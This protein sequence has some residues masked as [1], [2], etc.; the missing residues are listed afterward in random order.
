MR[1]V[2]SFR[3]RETADRLASALQARGLHTGVDQTDAECVVSILEEDRLS[4]AQQI[5]SEFT[6]S[7]IAGSTEM[8]VGK[9]TRRRR[10]ANAFRLFGLIVPPVTIALLLAS[11]VASL[12]THFGDKMKPVGL[13][14]GIQPF[15]LA[16]D[17]RMSWFWTDSPWSHVSRGEVWRL[18]T[19]ML[20]HFRWWHLMG[21]VLWTYSF[22][23]AVEYVRG[24]WRLIGLVLVSS[25]LSNVAQYLS[26]GPAFGG[27]SGVG[28]ALFGYVWMKS[29]FQPDVGLRMPR[30]VF[31]MFWALFLLCTSGFLGPIANTA[32]VVGLIVGML[33]GLAPRL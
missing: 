2:A 19:P 12:L 10:R 1:R 29:R 20:L 33:Y 32:H 27:L 26:Y 31:W 30:F 28:Y 16:R 18:F 22:S 24:P 25:A 13:W 15:W 3:N 17:G 11:I 6:E 4:D 14:L 5:A 9:K 21:N 8:P 7:P 23:G